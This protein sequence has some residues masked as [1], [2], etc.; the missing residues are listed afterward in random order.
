MKAGWAAPAAEGFRPK[1]PH[2]VSIRTHCPKAD[3]VRASL[4]SSSVLAASLSSLS[5]YLAPQRPLPVHT[6]VPG[7]QQ[8]SQWAQAVTHSPPGRVSPT[9]ASP[10]QTLATH[11]QPHQILLCYKKLVT[12]RTHCFQCQFL[13]WSSPMIRGF[14]TVQLRKPCWAGAC[15][16]HSHVEEPSEV[17]PSCGGRAHHLFLRVS[18]LTF[19]KEDRK[20]APERAAHGSAMEVWGTG[21]HLRSLMPKRPAQHHT[22]KSSRN[23][24]DGRHCSCRHEQG[25]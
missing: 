22:R 17:R 7:A 23:H 15:A 12:V 18:S 11:P 3:S 13:L 21:G 14:A 8:G 6:P 25:I 10:G 20:W 1:S 2:L 16:P 19:V 4:R 5:P 24:A 9:P